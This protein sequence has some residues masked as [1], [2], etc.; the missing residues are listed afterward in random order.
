MIE[1][2]NVGLY[3]ES[4]KALDG[5]NLSIN[6]G[7]LVCVLGASGSG[8]TSLVSL[9]G[10]LKKPSSGNVKVGV[11][12]EKVAI[13]FQNY[14]LLPWKTVY[15][16][17]MFTLRIRKIVDAKHRVNH[18][19][20]QLGLSDYASRYPHQLSGGQ[21]QRVAIARALA[22]EVDVLL[23]DEPF[24]AL[25]SLT[26]ESLQSLLLSIQSDMTV[27]FVTHNIEEAV[28]LGSR[29]IVLDKG[30]VKYDALNRNQGNRESLAFFEL[31]NEVRGI[32]HD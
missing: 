1:L 14:G 21:A 30:T 3:Y 28:F 16:N 7:E 29:I 25:D 27:I 13:I 4:E 22:L 10:G 26:K 24:S 19:L 9:I 18:I 6:K 32:L 5:I 15:D 2:H 20:D 11:S 31:C 8:K 12:A 17:V 23:M